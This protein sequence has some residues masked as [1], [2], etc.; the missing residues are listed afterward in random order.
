[1][2]AMAGLVAAGRGTGHAA[3]VLDGKF[4]TS[5][6]LSGP[7]YGITASMGAIRGNNLFHSFSQF[8]L[9]AGDVA[10]FSGPAN[11]QNILSRVTGGSPS[12]INGTIRSDIAGANF[13]FINPNGV[14][15]GPNAAVNVLGSFAVS[16][17]NYLKLADN[18]RFVAALDADD[19]MLSSAPV[20]AFGFLDGAN[21]VIQVKG[22]L[23]AA[24]GTSLSVVGSDVS[25]VDGTRLEALN[26][27]INLAGVTAPGDWTI[28]ASSPSAGNGTPTASAESIVIRAGRLVVE[29][30][31][32]N[33]TEG[34]ID[35]ALTEGLEVLNGGQ[36]TTS[37]AG[38]SKGG[39][40]AID[41]HSVLV[42]GQDNG[43]T[44]T[45]VAAE[46]SSGDPL[47]TGGDIVV[48]ATS[49]KVLRGAEVS[50][51]TF[52]AANAGQVDITTSTLL[53]D[54][55]P[56][57]SPTQ[58]AAN[59][60][61]LTGTASGAGGAIIVH[62]DSVAIE[63]GAAVIASTLGD[64]NAGTIDISAGSLTINAGTLTTLTSGAGLGGEIRL[65]CDNITLD[66]PFSSISATTFGLNSQLPAGNAGTINITA[67]S[68]RLQNDA[69]ISASTYGDGRGGDIN[70]K[71][72]FLV[73]NT[74]TSQGIFPGISASSNPDF[75]GG[76]GGGKGGDIKVK[77]GS[78]TLQNGML[79]SATTSTPGDGGSITI[80]VGAVTL[81]N[82]SSIQSASVA[83]GNAGTISLSSSQNI[84]LTENSSIST[85]APHTSGGDI[86]VQAGGDIQLFDSKITAQA[87]LN[88]GNITL[89]AP[90]LTYLLRSTVTGE[91]DTTGSGFGNGGNLTI[92]PSFLILNNGGLISKSSFGNGGNINIFSDF[93]FQSASLIDAS[94]PF[95]LPG[96]V[97]VS[98]PQVDLSGSLIG[99]PS[100]LL[101]LETELRPDCGVRL[102][103]NISSFI[104][105]GRGGLPIAPGGFVPSSALDTGN[106]LQ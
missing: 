82:K 84:L 25:V 83:G 98:A 94:A 14:M 6:A 62:A 44:A 32:I 31:R 51:S 47:A 27:R 23:K 50:V 55:G 12:S 100:N 42:D 11:I 59:A 19:S 92:D 52:G 95:G 21:G 78:L 71:A 33:G 68:L 2:L 3:V 26:G 72:N 96:T 29:N 79:I 99:L 105:V 30:A 76:P 88:G 93:F 13:F 67:G 60:A 89:S 45:R 7:N 54:A 65:N 69:G 5:G 36:I 61:G 41:S 16:T 101:D 17:A 9:N 56:N 48:H 81:N 90:S 10:A 104:V 49:V 40:I 80:D 102:S 37:A 73:L 74:A 103:G 70:I 106:G 28:P 8:D 35:I 91:A 22:S 64:A 1:M 75:F 53:V 87:G 58:I 4:G 63:N 97:T 85:S 38:A 18:A 20:K 43:T 39:N 77:A 15:F 34:G 66:G 86:H 24:P 57:Q 46:T